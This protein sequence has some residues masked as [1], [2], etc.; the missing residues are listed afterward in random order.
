MTQRKPQTI[1]IH[2]T[3]GVGSQTFLD[4]FTDVFTPPE[5]LPLH[6]AEWGYEARVGDAMRIRH[7]I[8]NAVKTLGVE[9]SVA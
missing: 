6:R 8:E 1:V 3:K 5:D 7:D 9:Q 4:A 2:V